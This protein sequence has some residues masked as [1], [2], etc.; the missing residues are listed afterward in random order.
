VFSMLTSILG[1]TA[2]F[3]ENKKGEY[4]AYVAARQLLKPPP[5]QPLTV[6]GG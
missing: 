4:T 1:A 3:T 2:P 6:A 5:P